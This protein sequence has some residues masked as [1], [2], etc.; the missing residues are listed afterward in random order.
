M[1]KKNSKVINQCA[2]LHFFQALC[3]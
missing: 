1:C 3:Y 2:K